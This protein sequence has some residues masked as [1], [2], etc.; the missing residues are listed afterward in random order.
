MVVYSTVQTAPKAQPGGVHGA[1][2]AAAYHPPA[3]PMM[4]SDATKDTPWETARK[5][6]RAAA[7]RPGLGVAGGRPAVD[8][9]FNCQ[10][11]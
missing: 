10:V 3:F 2:S 5:Q 6:R 8:A 11:H 1:L 7:C 4:T 9:L